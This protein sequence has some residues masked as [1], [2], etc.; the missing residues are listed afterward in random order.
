MASWSRRQIYAA[1][2]GLAA[3]FLAP[4]VIV[5]LTSL[6]SNQE[7]ARGSLIAWPSAFTL[8]NF[9]AG[10]SHFCIAERCT[11][12]RPYIVNSLLMK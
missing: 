7:T 11:G 6:R 3:F 5:V 4:L 9:S 10:W 1:L 12:V 8:E 2:L